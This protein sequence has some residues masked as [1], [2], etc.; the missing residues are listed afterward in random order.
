MVPTCQCE[1]LLDRNQVHAPLVVAGRA[2]VPERVRAE[3]GRLAVLAPGLRCRLLHLQQAGQP[4]AD[5]A[6]VDSAAALVAEQRRPVA[7]PGPDL[8][9]VPAR[10]R[11]SPSS[12]GT[13]R[14]R[15]PDV[16]AR[17]RLVAES[18]VDLAE[19]QGHGHLRGVRGD[20]AALEI[21]E[22][23]PVR[24]RLGVGDVQGGADDAFLR[25]RLDQGV[26][27]DDPPPAPGPW[28]PVPDSRSRRRRT[29]G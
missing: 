8:V 1:H 7:H 24:Q 12:I 23:V 14:G 10:I 20:D 16:F 5:R 17:P 25:E 3:P 27:V 26:G 6:P 9:E 28:P 19:Q 18:R 11:S 29:A 15:C 21:P 13:Q 4:V 2:G 22:R